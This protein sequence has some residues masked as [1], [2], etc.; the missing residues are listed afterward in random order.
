MDCIFCEINKGNL[1]ANIVKESDHCIA[2]TPLDMEVDG[3]LLVVPK[4]HYCDITDIASDTL[5]SVMCFVKEVCNSLKEKYNFTGFNLLN[6]SGV[7]A[8]QS[9]GHFHIHIIPRKENDGIEAWPKLGIGKN[10]YNTDNQL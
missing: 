9:V 10:I 8:Q 7:A 1:P 4:E 3:H 6:A 5:F 2:F